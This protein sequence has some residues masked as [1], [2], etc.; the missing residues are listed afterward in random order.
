MH[1]TIKNILL[2]LLGGSFLLSVLLGGSLTK[3]LQSIY[4]YEDMDH[5]PQSLINRAKT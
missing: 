3:V 2:V 1:R 5:T 4:D